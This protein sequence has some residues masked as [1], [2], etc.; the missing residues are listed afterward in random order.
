MP[1]TQRPYKDDD[2]MRDAW[3]AKFRA[4]PMDWEAAYEVYSHGHDGRSDDEARWAYEAGFRAAMATI[5]AI[6]KKASF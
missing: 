2:T 3:V 1:Q 5:A 4:D 6:A